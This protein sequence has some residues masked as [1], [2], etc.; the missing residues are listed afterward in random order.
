MPC[1]DICIIIRTEPDAPS[2]IRQELSQAHPDPLGERL[3]LLHVLVFALI[4]LSF[5]ET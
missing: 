5:P 2:L 4:S 1:Q 3:A